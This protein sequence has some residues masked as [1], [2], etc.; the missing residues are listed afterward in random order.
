[1][2]HQHSTPSSA[3]ASQSGV[4]LIEV[5]IS[6]LL[7]SLG[8]LGLIGLQAR[9]ISL[10]IDAE[11]RNRAA[12]IANDIATT[13]WTTRTVAIDPAAGSPSWNARA[14]NPQ[15]GGLP[16]GSVTITADTAAKTADILITW[17]PPQRASSEQDS[18]L[19]TRV[20]LPLT[21]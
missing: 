12:L 15:A 5:L 20:A 9:A 3:R 2:K 18:R 6:I 16:G 4:A 21:P 14:S 11:D 13:M 7:F 8:I 1:M 10:S 17:R 19:T